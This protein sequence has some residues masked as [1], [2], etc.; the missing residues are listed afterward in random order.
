MS[1]P[2]RLGDALKAAI[3]QIVNEVLEE[4]EAN[5]EWLHQGNS[6][7]GA[8]QDSKAAK[9]L[10]GTGDK[11]AVKSGRRYL[12]ERGALLEKLHEKVEP[13]A[14]PPRENDDEGAD[15]FL[16]AQ[17]LKPEKNSE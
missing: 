8:R 12:V 10:L 15:A 5:S 4:R 14:A 7:V 6:L 17:N 13:P 2:D 1:L 9:A 3:H 11:R 16:L